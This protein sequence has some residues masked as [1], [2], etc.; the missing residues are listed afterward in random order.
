MDDKFKFLRAAV[1][2]VILTANAYLE[3]ASA[4]VQSRV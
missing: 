3:Y 4:N 1:F 2:A